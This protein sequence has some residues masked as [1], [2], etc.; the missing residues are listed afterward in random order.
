[1]S[2][3]DAVCFQCAT[4]GTQFPAA[5]RPPACC[6][7]CE[8]ERQY[9]GHDGQRWTTLAGLRASHRVEVREVE[10]GIWGI[11][12]EPKFAIGQRALLV[13]TPA[14]NVLWDCIP[15]IDEAVVA[16]VKRLGGIAAIAISHPHYY[17]TMVEWSHAFGGAPIYLHAADRAHVMRP[18]PVIRFWEGETFSPLPGVTLACTGGHFDGYQVMHWAGGAG[19][20]GILFSGD[21][22]IVVMDRR[23]VSFMFSYPNL[24]P[25]NASAVRRIVAAL[26]PFDYERIYGAWWHS[27]VA[28]D[29]KGAV[30]RS[31]ERYFAALAG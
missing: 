25:L 17:S 4:C 8:D 31:A 5:P 14:G 6:P 19:G 18:D 15:L 11:G 27:I 20:R 23:W 13:R 29:G 22:P 21:Q 28:A 9:V 26:E 3:P 30:R 7:I 24:I 16:E 2:K 10:P 1:M 12:I